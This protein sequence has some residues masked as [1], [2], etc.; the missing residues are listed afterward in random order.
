MDETDLGAN[1][2][3]PPIGTAPYIYTPGVQ[4]CN[5]Q[6]KKVHKRNVTIYNIQCATI[7]I[8]K[9][10]IKSQY[11]H[12][13]ILNNANCHISLKT[14]YITLNLNTSWG[15][16]I[17]SLFQSQINSIILVLYLKKYTQVLFLHSCAII[18]CTT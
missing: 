1:P 4:T 8:T 13:Y 2:G 16:N 3:H 12:S 6:Y 14:L 11:T 7:T 17:Q 9:Y 18:I 5:V 15:Q 10:C